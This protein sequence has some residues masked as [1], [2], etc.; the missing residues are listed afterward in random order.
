MDRN[1]LLTRLN[2]LVIQSHWVQVVLAELWQ[3]KAAMQSP[4]SIEPIHSFSYGSRTR[5][6]DEDD[7]VAKHGAH[8][9]Q[10]TLA[11]YTSAIWYSRSIS[12]SIDSCQNKSSADQN[13]MTISRAQM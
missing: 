10:P 7:D 8:T 2:R 3:P 9:G 4:I 1:L 12:W 5:T 6:Y 13:H 11:A